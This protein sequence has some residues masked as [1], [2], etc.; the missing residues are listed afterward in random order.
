MRKIQNLKSEIPLEGLEGFYPE[1][2]SSREAELGDLKQALSGSDFTSIM[3]LAHKWKGF[4]APYGFGQLG[5]LAAELEEAA[6]NNSLDQCKALTQE[7]AEYLT[8]KKH[9]K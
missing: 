1:F 6:R 9:A 5:L 4:S 7:I 8:S 3:A 2:L